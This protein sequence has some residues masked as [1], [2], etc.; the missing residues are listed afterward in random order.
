[1][2]QREAFLKRLNE[3]LDKKKDYIAFGQVPNFESYR[4]VRGQIKGLQDAIGI[5]MEVL[6]KGEFDDE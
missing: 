5:Y 6:K 3:E 1:M 2:K 4:F